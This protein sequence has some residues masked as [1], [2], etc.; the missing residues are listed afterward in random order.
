MSLASSRAGMSPESMTEVSKTRAALRHF[1]RIRTKK[2]IKAV[3]TFEEHQREK[4]GHKYTLR[5]GGKAVLEALQH[6]LTVERESMDFNSWYDLEERQLTDEIA[7]GF[8][9]KV[10]IDKLL[11]MATSATLDSLEQMLLD[12]L[13]KPSID[14][15]HNGTEE[16]GSVLRRC[17]LAS[18]LPCRCTIA[19]VAGVGL[20]LRR[21]ASHS[22]VPLTTEMGW[23][24]LWSAIWSVQ[25]C[26]KSDTAAS[27]TSPTS[28]W[29]CCTR[30]SS[31]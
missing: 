11:K 30:C 5:L 20:A 22:F 17:K 13:N 9:L 12:V 7:G 21:I 19:S 6:D 24:M 25:S 3:K 18:P 8:T 10:E 27:C 2:A 31:R 28:R 23:E 4:L 26:A 14:S 1:V 16:L 29:T 15:S